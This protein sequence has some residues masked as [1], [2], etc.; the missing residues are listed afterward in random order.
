MGEPEARLHTCLRRGPHQI[1]VKM[2]DQDII[3]AF[4]KQFSLHPL[5][6]QFLDEPVKIL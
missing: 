1:S 6:W 5:K 2:S 3:S 4:S